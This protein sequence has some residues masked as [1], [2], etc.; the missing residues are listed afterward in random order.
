MDNKRHVN[1]ETTLH[2][3]TVTQRHTAYHKTRKNVHK[4]TTIKVGKNAQ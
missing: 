1:V 4:I 2:K 3:T